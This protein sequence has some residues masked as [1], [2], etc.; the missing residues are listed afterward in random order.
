MKSFASRIIDWQRR[1]GRHTLPWQATRDPYRVWLSEIMLQQTQ[2][3]TVVPYFERFVARFPDLRA[4]AAAR[5]DD[6][7]ALWSGLGYYSRARN[8][9]AAARSLVAE[10]GGAFPADPARIAQ[11]PGIGRSTAAAIAALAFGERCAI[12]DGNVKRVLARHG[13]V[14]GWPGD[15]RVETGL[16]ALAESLLPRAGIEAYTQGMMDLGALVCTRSRPDCAVCPVNA[17]CVAHVQQ[18]TAE[19]PT[20]RPQKVR[21]EKQVQVLLLLDRGELMLEKRP[22]QGIWGGLWSLPELPPDVDAAGHCR[23]ELGFTALEQQVL[24][25]FTHDFTHFRLHIR[26][27]RFHLAPREK[28]LPGHLWLSPADAL[29]AALPAPV[30]TLV[31]QLV[32]P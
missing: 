20:P 6:V 1:H 25:Q 30:R 18:R 27:V 24:P 28:T 17:D 8:L 4:L 5:E 12:L 9:H 26:P 7:L 15:K 29:D 22:P 11:L 19:L 23:N 21:P 31:G 2:V 14:A 13:G 3:S 16:W 32:R 10:C